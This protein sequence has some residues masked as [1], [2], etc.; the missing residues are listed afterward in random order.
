V[1]HLTPGPGIALTPFLNNNEP[2][3]TD[4]VSPLDGSFQLKIVTDEFP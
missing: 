3:I 1:A 4:A 2:Q